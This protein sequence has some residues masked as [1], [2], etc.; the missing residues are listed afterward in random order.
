MF[1]DKNPAEIM[2]EQED[3]CKLHSNELQH[4]RKQNNAK[5]HVQMV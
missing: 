3:K 4:R 5:L 1:Y 2:V